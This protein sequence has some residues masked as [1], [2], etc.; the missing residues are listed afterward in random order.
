VRR[1]AVPGGAQG[2]GHVVIH[3]RPDQRVPEPEALACLGQHTRGACLVHRRDQVRH[4]ASE[5]NRQIG[6]GEIR[7]EQGRRP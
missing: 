6:D 2:R 4:A 7:A 3:G 1:V 5:H